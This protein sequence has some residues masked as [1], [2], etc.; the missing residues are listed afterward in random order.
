MNIKPGICFVAPNI[1]P[2]LARDSNVKMVGGAEVQQSILARAF[3]ATG[4]RVTVACMDVGQPEGV[5]VDGVTV[6]NTYRPRSGLPILRFF[7]PH[8]SLTW[9]AL[10]RADA[11]IYY[12]RGCGMLTGIVAAF[13]RLHRRQF[14]F[15]GAHDHD[16]QDELPLLV[17]NR[18][19]IIYRWGLAYAHAV[20]VQ[21]HLQMHAAQAWCQN[22][23]AV[24]SCYQPAPEATLSQQGYVLWVARFCSWKRPEIFIEV[25]RR[26]P[27]FHFRMVGGFGSEPGE[28]DFFENMTQLA[29]TVPNLELVGFVP[30][31]EVEREFDGARIF[32]NTSEAEGFPNTFL[33]AWARGMPTVSFVQ[34]ALDKDGKA[35]GKAVQ[36]TDALV[37]TV[38]ELMVDDKVW[39]QEGR[40]CQQYFEQHHSVQQAFDAY[41]VLFAQLMEG[42]KQ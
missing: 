3:A 39:H 29:A 28:A 36:N 2:V 13:C 19:R 15:A 33:Q 6:H 12:Q 23:L 9:R 37:Q 7:H 26:L 22:L 24:S 18:D 35:I 11:D 32:V 34:P 38:S 40:R 41:A 25:A 17:K 21:N 14:V 5:D 16:F 1:Y 27:Q 4:Y 31:A 10:A 20:V 30:H 42:R 8:I